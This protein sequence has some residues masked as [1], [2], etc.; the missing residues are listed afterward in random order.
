MHRDVVP[1]VEVKYDGEAADGPV[2]ILRFE[3]E[4]GFSVSQG[5]D[6]RKIRVTMLSEA[7]QHQPAK[8][9]P[10]QVK[11]PAPQ[12]RQARAP[13]PQRGQKRAPQRQAKSVPKQGSQGSRGRGAVT[14]RDEGYARRGPYL[15]AIGSV[16]YEN[17]QG[18]IEDLLPGIDVDVQNSWGLNGSLGYRLHPRL[19]LEAQGEWYSE[20]NIDLLG[21]EAASFEGWSVTGL[22]KIYLYT[23]RVQP[24]AL[25]GGG[26]LDVELSDKL[27]L[28]LSEKQSGT[29][30]KWGGGIDVYATHGI[31]V[32]LEGVYSLP[33]GNVKDLDFW[34]LGMG[35][36]YRF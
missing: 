2:L 6:P 11:K 14:P 1:L 17:F 21:V 31:V 22:G 20:Y 4:T 32:S 34:T 35:L 24:Y 12:P 33:L 5:Q 29:V 8:R 15:G 3:K 16:A 26:Y 18:E 9:A 13:A 25:A 28:G 30:V 27:G 7:A 10:E 23:G 36:K 19:A